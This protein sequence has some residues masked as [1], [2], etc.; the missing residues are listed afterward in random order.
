M[1]YVKLFMFSAPQPSIRWRASFQ[2]ADLFDWFCQLT[3]KTFVWSFK[4]AQKDKTG[5][6]NTNKILPVVL[7]LPHFRTKAKKKRKK[8]IEKLYLLCIVFRVGYSRH[9]AVAVG[10]LCLRQRGALKD[11]KH[12][13]HAVNWWGTCALMSLLA[14]K[15]DLRSTVPCVLLQLLEQHNG[16]HFRWGYL[17]MNLLPR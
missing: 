16:G 5:L 12:E 17:L 6:T 11:T 3:L 8:S 7:H 9:G 14:K 2:P 10:R 13:W 4:L 15:R 1:W